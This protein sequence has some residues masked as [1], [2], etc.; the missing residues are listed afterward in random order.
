MAVRDKSGRFGKEK[1]VK[2]LYSLQQQIK[3]QN[4]KQADDPKIASSDT[5]HTIYGTK[6]ASAES[7]LPVTEKGR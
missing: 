2:R 6:H 5:G 3:E 1:R 4:R 7:N